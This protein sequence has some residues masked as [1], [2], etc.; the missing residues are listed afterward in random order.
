M[1][2]NELTRMIDTLAVSIASII[3]LVHF[4]IRSI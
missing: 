3:L 4:D 2:S 1:F